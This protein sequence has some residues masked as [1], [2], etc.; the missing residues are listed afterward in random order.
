MT[1]NIS[2]KI[3]DV[4]RVKEIKILVWVNKVMTEIK[5][6]YKEMGLCVSVFTETNKKEKEEKE[7]S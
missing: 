4:H 3:D 2:I 5:M 6:R 1:F 7:L